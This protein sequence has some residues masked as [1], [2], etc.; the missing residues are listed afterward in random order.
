MFYLCSGL[1]SKF[2]EKEQ[3]EKDPV[4]RDY[5]RKKGGKEYT[6]YT[7]MIRIQYFCEFLKKTPSEL[8]EEAEEEMDKGIKKR[9][10]S[11]NKHFL[12]YVDHLKQLGLS[13]NT[14]MSYTSTVKSF[15]RSYDIDVP[16]VTN[17]RPEKIVNPSL[18]TILSKKEIEIVLKH[19]G[20]RD[21]ATILLQ[22][23]S[24]MGAAEIRSLKYSDFIKSISKFID[25]D[26]DEL[27]IKSID[28]QLRK[29]K[30]LIGTWNVHRIKTGM[31]Y[32]TF[33][34]PESI[35]AILDYLLD[36]NQKRMIESVDQPLFLNR[37]SKKMTRDGFLR[38]YQRLN[39]KAGF[40]REEDNH[41]YFRSHKLRK[42]FTTSMMKSH[43][44]K[45]AIDWMLGHSINAT[46][47]AYFKVDVDHL[48][49]Q[50]LQ[51]LKEVTIGK[52]EVKQVHSN[53]YMDLVKRNKILEDKLEKRDLMMEKL[54]EKMEVLEEVALERF[55]KTS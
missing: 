50:Y 14:I 34:S 1:H 52:V 28:R 24:C 44:D 36:W 47:S 51:G 25:D 40:G 38:S 23:S 12:D 46:D 16:D 20:F 35:I 33:N 49:N 15:Y 45:T 9:K 43:V 55:Q 19:A 17:I 8:I 21:K 22:L 4:F 3:I 29:R 39:E 30:D 2:M 13:K 32:I 7:R 48:K 26:T 53:E 41:H 10:R 54:S 42:F 6:Q 31:P 11:I 27:D 37:A 18:D 5:S